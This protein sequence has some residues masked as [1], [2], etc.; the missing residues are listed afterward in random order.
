VLNILDYRNNHRP[1]KALE[2]L[3]T[4]FQLTDMCENTPKWQIYTHCTTLCSAR[5][6]RIYV[7][8]TLLPNTLGSQILAT[9]Y[10]DRK[11]TVLKIKMDVNDAPESNYWKLNNH[12][13]KDSDILNRFAQHRTKWKRRLSKYSNLLQWW[14]VYI[15]DVSIC[16][17]FLQKARSVVTP[18]ASKN[19]STSS[20]PYWS[21]GSSV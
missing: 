1:G 9:L 8:Q 17:F 20:V 6:D 18:S 7:A 11:A 4:N 13:L 10:S 3:T 19:T 5:L 14:D 21:P 2:E 15:Y 16:G 12:I